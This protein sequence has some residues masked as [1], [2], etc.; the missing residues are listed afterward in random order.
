[1]KYQVIS[2]DGTVIG[3][4]STKGQAKRSAEHHIGARIEKAE[5]YLLEGE[6]LEAY[7]QGWH[8]GDQGDYFPAGLDQAAYDWGHTD[9]Q[10]YGDRSGKPWT[11]KELMT[12]S[13]KS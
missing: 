2:S 12:L 4:Y 11:L 10:K 9:G 3:T 6:A 8:D 7:R 13:R 1:M 5:A